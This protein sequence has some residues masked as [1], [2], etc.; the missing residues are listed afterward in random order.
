MKKGVF[1]VVL[2]AMFVISCA[3]SVGAET[4]T[5]GGDTAGRSSTRSAN[6]VYKIGDIG[7]AGGLIFYDKGDYSDSWRYL[8]AAPE[9]TE[10]SGLSWGGYGTNVGT[11]TTTGIGMGKINTQ[12]IV[13]VMRDYGIAGEAAQYC[14]S[15]VYGR[16]DD[17]FL[18]SK[19]ELN[20]M[21]TN[22][23]KPLLDCFGNVYWSSS[24]G[25]QYEYS[26]WFQNFGNGEQS[27]L[28]HKNRDTCYVRAVWRF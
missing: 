16:Y 15:L 12:I 7:P 18:P 25:R 28:N 8:E 5:T 17:W 14:D 26:A 23:R 3:S 27:A 2:L 22:L 24:E 20:L 11:G 4:G 10:Q 9:S 1:S 6:R 19:D 21:Y 13:R